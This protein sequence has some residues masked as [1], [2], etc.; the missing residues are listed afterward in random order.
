MRLGMSL[1]RAI[2]LLGPWLFAV[3]CILSFILF[4]AWVVFPVLMYFV[5]D[6]IRKL[7]A[8]MRDLQKAAGERKDRDDWQLKKQL[9]ELQRGPQR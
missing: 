3:I 2:E 9:H 5:L 8:E 6:Q 7:L 1:N 4:V